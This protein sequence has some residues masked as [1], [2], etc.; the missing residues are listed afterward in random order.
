ME[1]KIL[2]SPCDPLRDRCHECSGGPFYVDCNHLIADDSNSGAK[3]FPWRAI[4]HAAEVASIGD[5]AWI[6][7]VG[8]YE[9]GVWSSRM[10]ASGVRRSSLQRYP[11]QERQAI[12]KGA[13]FLSIGNSH[14]I[15]RGLKVLESPSQGFR[16]EGP[17]DSSDPLAENITISGN[18]IC[19][20]C[21]RESPVGA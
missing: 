8:V 17:R 12:V 16:F 4:V 7:A 14:I 11:G 18:H 15:V 13:R 6:K 21:P 5:N 19:D 1:L 20:T 2:V 3:E 10:P 9:D